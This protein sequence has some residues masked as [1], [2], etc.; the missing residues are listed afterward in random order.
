[1]KAATALAALWLATGL[2]WSAPLRWAA[3][4]DILTLDP[5]SQNHTT[6][7]TICQQV[8]E[9]L[10]RRNERYQP[11]PSLATRWTALSPTQVRFELRRGVKFHDGS[12]F[13][14]DDVVFSFD[15]IRQPTGT[16][17]A[18][19]TGIR[20][21][22]KVDSH[23]IDVML[24]A[25]TPTLLQNI[26]S[27][28]I[29]SKAW[30]QKHNAGSIADYKSKDENFASRNAMGTGP[31]RFVGWQPDQ[32]IR[33][34]RNEDW[35]D[36]P[37]GNITE[38]TYL[39]IKSAAPRGAALLSGQVDIVTDLPPT[40]FLRIKAG[41][42][43]KVLEG[44][45]VRTV[46]F[47][48]DQGSDELRDARPR[49]RNPFKDRR[50][51]EALNL[52]LD[53]E[54]IRRSIMRGL[55]VPAAL[56]VAPGANGWEAALD[57]PLKPDLDQARRLLTA[58]GYPQGF[59]VPLHCPN[60]RYVNDEAVCQA[61]VAMWAKIGVKVKLIVTP[62]ATHSQIFQRSE[63]AFYMLGSSTSTF[64]AQLSLQAVAHSR[65][66]GADGSLNFARLSD[67][68]LDALIQQIKVE[69]DTARRN[70]QIREALLRLRDEYLFVP[71]HHQIRPWA[72]KPGVSTLHRSN[73]TFEARFTT[74]Q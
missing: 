51:R 42:Q 47:A 60:D 57:V 11:E 1:V 53:R 43:F 23:T 3:Q 30:S 63:A 46:F 36:T 50:V 4:N 14:A 61:A 9:A 45:E 21:I 5:Q 27:F 35:W 6:S 39:P 18:Y 73:D 7:I 67:A 44:P 8:Y 64:D 58:A 71:I 65:T 34:E 16:M 56:M 70:A 26:A 40:D 49:G 19:V 41:G 38:L 62:F 55:S 74:L 54:A 29:M 13:T 25:P 10:T 24:E 31:Y 12:P 72:M 52:A 69:P 68:R 37:K 32:Q 28:Y 22:R 17:Q 15:R 33:L 20:E 2:A 48:M 59:E 66:N